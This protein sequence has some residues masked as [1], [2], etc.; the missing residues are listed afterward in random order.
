[1]YKSAKLWVLFILIILLVN[2]NMFIIVSGLSDGE[3]L[4][5]AIVGDA[6]YSTY[7]TKMKI[8][9]EG[10][11]QYV[12][13]YTTEPHDSSYIFLFYL[14][15]G[16]LAA[17]F[18]LDLHLTFHAARFI[19]A[20]FALK[21]LYRFFQKYSDET[22][23]LPIFLLAVFISGSYNTAIDIAP[24]YHLYAGMMG[25][26][27]Y[28]LTLIC[29]LVFF[30][31]VLDYAN[32]KGKGNLLKSVLALNVLAVVHPFMVVL[33]G[34]VIT[35]TVIATKKLAKTLPILSI[36]AVS[37]MP[38]MLYFFYI[39]T[40]NPA[41]IG[42]RA[43]AVADLP[44]VYHLFLYGL[45]SLMAYCTIVLWIK[46]KITI[47]DSSVLFI[48]WLLTALVLSFTNLITSPLQWFFFASVPVAYLSYKFIRY[49]DSKAAFKI[50]YKGRSVVSLLILV[51]LV[52]PTADMLFLIDHSAVYMLKHKEEFNQ[53]IIFSEDM[54][55][56]EWLRENADTSDIILADERIGNIIPFVTNSITFIG[57]Q[58]E[59]LDYENKLKKVELLLD[60]SYTKQEAVGFLEESKIKYIIYNKGEK[61]GYEFLTHILS[62]RTITLYKYAGS[63]E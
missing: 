5:K 18:H 2:S 1:V 20:F 8:G 62:G 15:L 39:F 12:N 21:V 50:V 36:S 49:L 28:M 23:I 44:H 22:E 53:S 11:W 6:D 29:L 38:A 7:I 56:Y 10:G 30:D 14:F 60:G 43:Q 45:G 31:S 4:G 47:A 25:F 48:V 16:H 27:H 55:C 57:H 33:A 41:L 46:K 19:L 61:T 51:M 52:I 13:K 59:T 58:H 42:W 54:K 17:I 35:G 24:Q 3:F 40:T 26:T 32:R 63:K 9:Y 37:S 34:L